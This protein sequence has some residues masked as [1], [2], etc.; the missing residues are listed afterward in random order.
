M[1]SLSSTIQRQM[2]LNLQGT[3]LAQNL[4]ILRRGRSRLSISKSMQK[5]SLTPQNGKDK[6]Q[7]RTAIKEDIKHD[8]EELHDLEPENDT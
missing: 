2:A 8:L 4:P 3:Q 5:I 6:K 1:A 7:L